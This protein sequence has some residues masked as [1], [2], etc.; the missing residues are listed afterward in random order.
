MDLKKS[1]E[2]IIYFCIKKKIEVVPSNVWSYDHSERI[3]TEVWR[4]RPTKAWV[5]TMLHELGHAINR[6]K[7]SFSYK[8]W[9]ISELGESITIDKVATVQIMREEIE[10]WE[11]GLKLAKRLDIEI[12][13]KDFDRYAS[14]CLMKYMKELPKQYE[15]LRNRK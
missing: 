12:N 7:K 14:N 1:Y 10:A 11:T 6:S 9:R 4:G 15:A 3:I 13:Q 8:S 2:N 5:Y